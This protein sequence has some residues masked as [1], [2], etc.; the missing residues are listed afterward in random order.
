M[1]KW[2]N[3]PNVTAVL[4]AN[5]PGQESGKALV[6]ILWGKETPSEKLQY[7]IAKDSNDYY[8]KL[9]TT[10]QP[11]PQINYTEG[12]FTDYRYFAA[13]NISV[14]YPFG[15]GLSYTNF[16]YCEWVL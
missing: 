15:F 12:V 4:W 13:Q 2:I 6:D 11:Q 1:E 16:R 8:A 3:H 10:P 14:R 7:T 5:L 9:V